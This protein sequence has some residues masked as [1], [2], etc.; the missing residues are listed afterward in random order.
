[1]VKKI[2]VFK[3]LGIPNN[4]QTLRNIVIGYKIEQI[5]YMYINIIFSLIGFSIY[6]AYY[7]SD[8]RQ[9]HIDTFNIFKREFIT[10]MTSSSYKNKTFVTMSKLLNDM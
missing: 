3:S 1:M 2:S 6:K 9:K 10:L 8:C 7:A 4:I 5:D